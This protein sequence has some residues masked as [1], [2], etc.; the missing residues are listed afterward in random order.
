MAKKIVKWK[1]PEDIN[2]LVDYKRWDE[3]GLKIK[4]WLSNAIECATILEEEWYTCSINYT[5]EEWRH[6][7]V[8]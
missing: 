2:I 1:W 7:K 3:K 5:D 4:H 8:Q 6:I